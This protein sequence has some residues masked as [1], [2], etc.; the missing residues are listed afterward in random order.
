MPPLRAAEKFHSSFILKETLS[1][2][3]S[4]TA[5][6]SNPFLVFHKT[7]FTSESL[8]DWLVISED[9]L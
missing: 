6:P 2:A 7:G 1:E 8:T 9:D 5:V 3:R 4:F